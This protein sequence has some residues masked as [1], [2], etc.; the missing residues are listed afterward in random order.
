VLFGVGSEMSERPVEILLVESDRELCEMIAQQL[1]NAMFCRVSSADSAAAALREELTGQHELVIISA[2][3]P[4][5]EGFSLLRELRV[6]NECPVLV[7]AAETRV[8][9]TLEA[10]RHGATGWFE[11]PFDLEQFTQAVNT[12]CERETKK[13]RDQA[14]LRR[15]RRVSSKIVKERE[16]LNERMELLCRDLV[17]AYRRLAEKV[18]EAGILTD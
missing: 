13:R 3:L 2:E 14:R 12:A 4:D 1:E 11:K 16:D 6:T 5:D 18:T 8:E 15:L 9:H 17:Q 7:I 10:L